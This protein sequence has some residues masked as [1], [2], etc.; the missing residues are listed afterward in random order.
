MK[1]PYIEAKVDFTGVKIVLEVSSTVNSSTWKK[2]KD[3]IIL[4]EKKDIISG[5]HYFKNDAA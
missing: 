1:G 3:V 4:E 5:K 2:A